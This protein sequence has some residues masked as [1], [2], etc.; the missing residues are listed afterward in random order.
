MRRISSRTTFFYKRLFPIF[1]F[2]FLAFFILIGL[3][4]GGSVPLPAILV[5]VAIAVFGCFLMKKLI[6]DLVDEVWDAGDEL[7][8]KNKGREDRIP[9]STIV[10]VSYSAFTSPPRVTLTLRD[11]GVP[12]RE[13]TF[14][15]PV[16]FM[17]FSK[18]PIID[19]LI[20][21]ID[22]KRSGH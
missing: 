14:C 1:W 5:P 19:E 12:G 13:V 22:K 18:S 6:F 10:N 21:R 9:L 2:G 20:E 7:I 17:P 15:P 4:A 3:R 8:V 11:G 16:R